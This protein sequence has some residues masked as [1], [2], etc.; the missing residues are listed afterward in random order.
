M[1]RSGAMEG[2]MAAH[3]ASRGVPMA[4]HN[5]TV[6]ALVRLVRP[7]Q[8]VKN[9][10]VLVALVTAHRWGDPHA[11]LAALRVAA[12]FCLVASAV[13]AVNDVLDREADAAH[14]AK[15]DR[16]VA[17]G[18]VSPGL[19][20][21]IAAALAASGI[22]LAAAGSGPALGALA[23]YAA[24]ALAYCMLFKRLLWIDVVALAA[25]YVLRV[26]AGA[27]AIEVAP[28]P[29]LLAFAGFVFASLA[30]L[31]R[32][33]DLRAFA[34]D[35][36]PGRAYRRDDSGV[37]LAVGAA[38]GVVAVL[39][40]AL[41]A[42]SPDVSAM[43]EHPHWIWLLCPLL[44]YWLARMWML[45]HRAA[46]DADP[47]VFALRDPASWAVAGGFVAAVALAL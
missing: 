37:V 35:V 36:L 26:V 30:S 3:G 32:Y 43:Y 11:V 19:A 33:A 10:L 4:R 39:V 46:V 6:H 9:V 8:W 41:Y 25:L 29:W 2:P 13:Y 7:H 45:A 12:A 47:I 28:S 44:L 16:P 40:L 24:V 27:W 34:G 23:A 1:V 38:A 5:R 14:P 20:L 21:G 42:N 15:R 22:A 31:K 18:A 17:C